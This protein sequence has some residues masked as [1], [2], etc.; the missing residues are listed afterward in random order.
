M[1]KR[2]RHI[3][4]IILLITQFIVISGNLLP[5]IKYKLNIQKIAAR[6]SILEEEAEH[7]CMLEDLLNLYDSKQ[8]HDKNEREINYLVLSDYHYYL[9]ITDNLTTPFPE[10]RGY[11][12]DITINK[13]D[14]S[15]TPI[16]P[17]P[18]LTA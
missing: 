2:K 15:Y 6:L 3:F 9:Q 16:D 4:S 7:L 17:P 11:V 5:V 14:L 8:L 13:E 18:E 1:K 12:S 10:I